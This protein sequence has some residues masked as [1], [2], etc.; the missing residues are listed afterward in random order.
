MHVNTCILLYVS[1]CVCMFYYLHKQNAQTWKHQA[2]KQ[3]HVCVYTQSIFNVRTRMHLANQ[4]ACMHACTHYI[5]TYT[6]KTNINA[7]IHTLN[8]HTCMHTHWKPIF[9]CAYT[10]RTN[11]HACIHTLNR[12]T[13]KHILTEPKYMHACKHYIHAYTH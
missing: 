13:Y 6:Q 1:M 5:H 8:Q 12:H 3:Q 2:P 11:V 10:Q 7:C 4:H 9:M